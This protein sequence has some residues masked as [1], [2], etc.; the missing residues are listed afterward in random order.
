[1]STTDQKTG[2]DYD[3]DGHRHAASGAHRDEH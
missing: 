2:A 1:M 3:G